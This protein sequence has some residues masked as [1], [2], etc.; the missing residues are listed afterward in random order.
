[1][2]GPFWRLRRHAHPNLPPSRGK[3]L[4]V[5]TRPFG[6][7]VRQ[8]QGSLR[9][10]S[11]PCEGEGTIG[12]GRLCASVTPILTLRQAQGRLFPLRGG[13]DN[14][15]GRAM[16][17]GYP[18]CETNPKS[19]SFWFICFISSDFVAGRSALLVTDATDFGL[20]ESGFDSW[21]A[22]VSRGG[23]SVVKLRA[24]CGEGNGSTDVLRRQGGGNGGVGCGGDWTR[25]VSG[26]T[27]QI[28]WL[29]Y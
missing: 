16:G 28:I 3:G 12:R 15:S 10:G 2:A 9:A 22:R 26:V 20:D 5:A 29:P 24:G 4:P 21:W 18:P 19:V 13:R 7:P 6:R 25:G 17:E 1:M 27:W 14:R 23:Q 8:A 11:S